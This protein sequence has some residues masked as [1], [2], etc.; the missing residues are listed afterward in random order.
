MI[1]I[2]EFFFINAKT[3]VTFA[4]PVA[5]VRIVNRIAKFG[6]HYASV[7]RIFRPGQPTL[8]RKTFIGPDFLC[9]FRQPILQ[10]R[11][12]SSAGDDLDYSE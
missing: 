9:C 12:L 2:A 8:N 10:A 1:S 11:D 6:R 3:F 5:C 7:L 4:E